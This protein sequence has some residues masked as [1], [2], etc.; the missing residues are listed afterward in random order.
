M[1]LFGPG[2]DVKLKER[3]KE[4]T[5]S[6]GFLQTKQKS[7]SW[8]SLKLFLSAIW[9]VFAESGKRNICLVGSPEKEYSAWLHQG[10]VQE[11]LQCVVGPCS[12]FFWI[13]VLGL[14]PSGWDLLEPLGLSLSCTG[15]LRECS[16]WGSNGWDWLKSMVEMQS[17]NYFPLPPPKCWSFFKCAFIL[18]R[19]K[20]KKRKAH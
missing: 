7:N 10:G 16:L 1:D 3:K 14:L 4:D 8:K 6:G 13:V 12:D 15:K 18:S 17:Y 20:E 9:G 19:E 11:F 5:L 2:I